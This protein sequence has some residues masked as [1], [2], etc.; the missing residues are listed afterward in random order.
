MSLWDHIKPAKKAPAATAV[1]LTSDGAVLQLAWDDGQATRV[2]ARTLRQRCPCA[3]C[4]EEWTG[5]RTFEPDRI[6][7][8]TRILELHPVGNYALSFTFS[9]AH[10]TGIFNWTLLRET[11]EPSAG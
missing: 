9:D 6:S 11:S 4:V 7:P 5:R 8:D 10:R 3:E 2:S 1:E